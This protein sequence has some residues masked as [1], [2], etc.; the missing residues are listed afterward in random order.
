M[1]AIIM[2]IC[3]FINVVIITSDL[4]VVISPLQDCED[5]ITTASGLHPT[6]C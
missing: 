2:I 4:F 1:L 5:R 6:E 3:S